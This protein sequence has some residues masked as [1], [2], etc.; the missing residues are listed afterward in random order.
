MV[1]ICLHFIACSFLTPNVILLLN[2]VNEVQSGSTLGCILESTESFLGAFLA[3][4]TVSLA[5]LTVLG[6]EFLCLRHWFP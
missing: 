2:N 3:Q 6:S 4:L 1:G 5:S